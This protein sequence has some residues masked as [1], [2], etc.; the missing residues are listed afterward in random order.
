MTVCCVR[1]LIFLSQTV[2]RYTDPLILTSDVA[3]TKAKPALSNPSDHM[4][5]PLMRDNYDE[6]TD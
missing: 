1:T 5:P 4:P 3:E 2:S 6:K